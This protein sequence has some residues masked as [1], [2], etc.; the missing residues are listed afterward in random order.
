MSSKWL[1][2]RAY[3]GQVTVHCSTL[4]VVASAGMFMVCC[5]WALVASRLALNCDK[6]LVAHAIE[7]PAAWLLRG[8]SG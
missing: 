6:G 1:R 2:F 4:S 3:T 5:R 8:L 7:L